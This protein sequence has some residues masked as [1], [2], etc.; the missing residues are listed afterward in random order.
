ML[1]VCTQ[2]Q[3]VGLHSHRHLEYRKNIPALT[4]QTAPGPAAVHSAAAVVHQLCS[5]QLLLQVGPCLH[6][7]CWHGALLLQETVLQALLLR[8]MMM[9]LHVLLLLVIDDLSIVC[10]HGREFELCWC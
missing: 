9:I 5:P 10:W 1:T 7:L 2:Q 4:S 8:M 6:G 3:G